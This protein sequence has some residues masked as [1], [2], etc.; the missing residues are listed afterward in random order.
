M[1]TPKMLDFRPTGYHFNEPAK[2]VGRFTGAG[3]AVP[4]AVANVP[5]SGANVVT[6][7]RSGVGTMT[8]TLQDLVGVIQNY[9]FWIGSTN[10]KSVQCT[11]NATTFVFSLQVSWNVNAV[12]VDLTA[13]EEL[14][15][16]ITKAETSRP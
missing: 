9:D 13:A 10:A 12:A 15:F 11:V 1:P 8:A 14:V 4:T 3:A 6:L 7:A 2:I 16:E 5:G